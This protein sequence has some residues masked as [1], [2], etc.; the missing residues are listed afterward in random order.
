MSWILRQPHLDILSTELADFGSVLQYGACGRGPGTRE[1]DN[2]F[3]DQ[4]W[5]LRMEGHC[6]RRIYGGQH[7]AGGGG[8]RGLREDAAG[9]ASG[10]GGPRP[11]L[12]GREFCG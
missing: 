5:H 3:S 12:P 10:F 1:K 2:E 8:L 4:V 9:A 6:G 7:S 11:A